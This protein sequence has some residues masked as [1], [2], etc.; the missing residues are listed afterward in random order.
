MAR[1]AGW[2]PQ[3]LD[4]E[5]YGNAMDRLRECAQLVANS[6]RS[7]CPVGTISR[8]IYRRGPY[9]GQTWT[10]RDAGALKKTIR[11]TERKEKYGVL[12]A[13]FRNIRVYA[14]NFDVYYAKIVEYHLGNGGTGRSFLRP[15][16][17]QNKSAMKG[18]LEGR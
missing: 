16:L 5:I 10:K 18:I 7:Q 17:N 9:A 1:V 6:A 4:E 14:G 8:P 12:I 15:A 2:N 3:V 13:Q 11:I